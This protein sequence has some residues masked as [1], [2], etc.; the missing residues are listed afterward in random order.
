MEW[1]EWDNVTEDI[2][3]LHMSS[4]R[5]EL[6]GRMETTYE[7][8]GRGS[9]ILLEFRDYFYRQWLPRR[10]GVIVGSESRFWKW[11]IYHSVRGAALT[12]NP[13]EQFNAVIKTV[14]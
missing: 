5:I 8:W 9:N 4:S 7:S 10:Q 14:N 12:N 2:Y 6:E 1:H 13:N 11:Q 3:T